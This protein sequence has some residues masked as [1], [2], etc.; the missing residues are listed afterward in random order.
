MLKH[1]ILLRS[2][3]MGGLAVLIGM[4]TWRVDA[5][6]NPLELDTPVSAV[7]ETGTVS[8]WQFEAYRDDVI[9]LSVNRAEGDLIPILSLLDS[10]EQ[11]QAQ[12]Q[13]DA[14]GNA[15]L[16]YRI[17]RFGQYIV[18]I[19]PHLAT[20]GSFNL[21]LALAESGRR[22]FEQGNIEYGQPAVQN[23]DDEIPYH[24]WTFEGENGQ[25]VDI[26]VTVL[27]GDLQP[28]IALTSPG[29]IILGRVEA[30]IDENRGRL[31]AVRLPGD[32]AYEVLVRRAGANFGFDGNSAGRYRLEVTLRNGANA[33]A[34]IL[35]P[36]ETVPGR[37]TIDSP[38]TR[39]S[40]EA[41]GK[42]LIEV[43]LAAPNCLVDLHMF[44][45]G[46]IPQVSAIGKSPFVYPVDFVGLEPDIIEVAAANCPGL[47]DIDFLIRISPYEAN[48][49]LQTLPENKEVFGATEFERWLFKGKAGDIINLSARHIDLRQPLEVR[50]VAPDQSQLYRSTN[51]PAFE[52]TLILQTDGFY[53]I[54]VTPSSPYFLQK[55]LIGQENHLFST[56]NPI[57]EQFLDVVETKTWRII[58][59]TNLE[60]VLVVEAP[61]GEIVAISRSTP[62]TP[63]RLDALV[64]AHPGRYRIKVYSNQRPSRLEVS[65]VFDFENLLLSEGKAILSTP[66][67]FH[68][69]QV[70]LTVGDIFKLRLENLR[71]DIPLPSVMLLDQTGTALQPQYQL[72]HENSLELIG[73]QPPKTGIYTILVS[74]NGAGNQ[75]TYQLETDVE[76]G[77]QETSGIVSVTTPVSQGFLPTS[78]VVPTEDYL[79][80]AFTPDDAALFEDAESVSLPNLI[81]GEIL[82]NERRDIWRLNIVR[83]QM[84][85][86][87]ATS[88]ENKPAPGITLINAEGVTVVEHWEHENPVS[89]VFY[90]TPI[91]STYYLVVTDDTQGGKYLLD[92]HIVPGLDETVS[93]V[94][95]A[96]PLAVGQPIIGELTSQTE[97]D[98][99]AFWGRQGDILSISADATM[100]GFVP[101]LTLTG[102]R[103]NEIAEA[104]FDAEQN[105]AQLQTLPLPESG[106]YTITVS[107]IEFEEGA[108]YGRYTLFVSPLQGQLEDGG[109]LDGT[110]YGTISDSF[111]EDVWL[112]GATAGETVSL[113]LEPLAVG[114]PTGLTIALADTS[115]EIFY[116]SQALLAEAKVV[117]QDIMLPRT[118]LYQVRV[119]GETPGRYMLNLVKNS[120][121]LLPGDH[122]I[123]Y[124]DTAS[125]IF[126]PGN[127]VDRW[128]LAGNQ[129]DVIAVALRPVRGDVS[130]V[131][132]EVEGPDGTIIGVGIDSGLGG[133]ARTE[134]IILPA[135]GIYSIL[136]GM[137]D[138]Q[139]SGALAYDLSVE[140]QNRLARSSGRLLPYNTTTTGIIYADDTQDVWLFEG[141][142]GDVIQVNVAGDGIL[143]PTFFLTAFN[144]AQ[145]NGQY[146][147]L[148]SRTG[149]ANEPARLVDYVLPETGAYAISVSGIGGTTGAYT[150][151]VTA[152]QQ[153]IT[154]PLPSGQSQAGNVK[155]GDYEVW[156][157]QATQGDK[158]S[159]TVEPI[160]RS[161]LAPKLSLLDSSG[162]ILVQELGISAEVTTVEN[163][164]LPDSGTYFL[165]VQPVA[166]DTQ[167]HY[168][169][170]ASLEENGGTLPNP[171]AYDDDAISALSDENV[172]QTWFF[173][174]QAGDVIALQ[175]FGTS[176]NLDTTL[177]LY[178]S[179]GNVIAAGDDTEISTDAEIIL[180]LPE[181]ERYTVEVARYGKERG[182][183]SGNYRL[184]L[185]LLYRPGTVAANPEAYLTYGERVTGETQPDLETADIWYFVGQA[186]DVINIDLQ[187]PTGNIPLLLSLSDSADNLLQEGVRIRERTSIENFTLPADG[188]YQ[189]AIQPTRRITTGEYIP[190]TLSLDL[191]PGEQATNSDGGFIQIGTSVSG[192]F[193]GSEKVHFWLYNGQAGEQISLSLL[194]LSGL[195]SPALTIFAPDGRVLAN[196]DSLSEQNAVTLPLNLPTSGVYQIA[197][198]GTDAFQNYRLALNS[199][200]TA[201]IAGQ[202]LLGRVEFG[203]LSDLEPQQVWLFNGEAGE[204]VAIQAIGEIIFSIRLENAEGAVLATS[205][206]DPSTKQIILPPI[207]LPAN[208]TYRVIVNREGGS[209]GD[210]QGR[211]RIRIS[212][213]ITLPEALT[214][215]PLQSS[216][217]T[218]GAVENTQNAYYIFYADP[219]V[220]VSLD[221]TPVSG[222][223]NP[224]IRILN[225]SGEVISISGGTVENLLV[226]KAGYYL[227][228]VANP[229]PLTYTLTYADRPSGAPVKRLERDVTTV[230]DLTSS[231]PVDY[232]SFEAT[233]GESLSIELSAFATTMR[234]DLV[235]FAPD[236][237]PMRT[238]VDGSDEVV[239][240]PIF[241]PRSGLYTLRVGTWL[242]LLEADE[243]GYSVRVR[244]ADEN[245]GLGSEGGTISETPVFGGISEADPS[246][247]W[248]FEGQAGNTI[249]ITLQTTSGDAELNVELIAPD[250]TPIELAITENG[251]SVAT[252]TM[253][254]PTNG[255]YTLKVVL[256]KQNSADTTAYELTLHQNQPSIQA[257]LAQAQ[258]IA[259]G[260]QVMGEI[261]VADELD[262]WV[263]FATQGQIITI[264]TQPE[265]SITL[266]SPNGTPLYASENGSLEQILL[267]EDGLY[268]VV[269]GGAQTS[270]TL[271][272]E[273]D[274]VR[275]NW[276]WTLA[277]GHLE[278]AVLTYNSPVHE[279]TLTGYHVGE[280]AIVV[281]PSSQAWQ[282]QT[283]VLNEQNEVIATGESQADGSVLMRLY[284]DES[285]G[286]KYSLIVTADIPGGDYQVLFDA[287]INA[288]TPEPV[289]EASPVT[290]RIS[291]FNTADEWLWEGN[292]SEPL[293]IEAVQL[294]G[295]FNMSIR[296]FAPGNLFLQEFFADENGFI[297]AENILLPVQGTYIIQVVRTDNILS[298]AQGLY[299]L[300]VEANPVP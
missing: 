125:G 195:A 46:V 152:L 16:T 297:R 105:T 71:T 198:V 193:A 112:V 292:P 135:T 15:T 158:L 70:P 259:I 154:L 47:D 262:A 52:Q 221:F 139:F 156:T 144:A 175:A 118:G 142:E 279:W 69:W 37:L 290:G 199:G 176:G 80:P 116:S 188:I 178:D 248:V 231:S 174:G 289:T 8:R 151:N 99:Y 238:Y 181:T 165:I 217:L 233:A 161:Q 150:L 22:A 6:E 128:L 68:Y 186:S 225:E 127:I 270:Y 86:F 218:T 64:L 45:D 129:G 141:H 275:T 247:R 192:D 92:I 184:D 169:I 66:S 239:F 162:N 42:H 216:I 90:R 41:F 44:S 60:A 146:E 115:G 196:L 54:E 204:T 210:A 58:A 253:L 32:G 84:V 109:V 113:A 164:I 202:L 281:R 9:T 157:I 36:N 207:L 159:L 131:G 201:A 261:S 229:M 257:I 24:V 140:R 223:S 160:R 39:Y 95:E 102:F 191:L 228:E 237:K 23:L 209:L 17:P 11:L 55:T 286:Q 208:D 126:T 249:S 100:R 171:L 3:L 56:Q 123:A 51:Q 53:T 1:K 242:N 34:N 271:L 266:I 124:G 180:T 285:N 295:D 88:L 77:F 299:Q 167:G 43:E 268:S 79:A 75:L 28:V 30:Q 172:L 215:Q 89:Q 19:S 74:N 61:T 108:E 57:L 101:Q 137:P 121:Y 224:Q 148:L 260:E 277:L 155:T 213:E 5:Q 241:I 7:L 25:A 173:D 263:F 133:G 222:E 110:A 163:Y 35:T 78:S 227:I 20:T 244:I 230:G 63:P 170:T 265:I 93:N 147:S 67:D 203:L 197:V 14:N 83:G 143:E 18:E 145:Q 235:L 2:L 234:P 212:A 97:T 179:A 130:S 293:T 134:N 98:T 104:T 40:I 280:Y 12:L 62:L 166:S 33:T 10:D 200:Q 206:I 298:D 168:E 136:V 65:A 117:V 26:T 276:R 73:F 182:Y 177:T 250:E 254:L 255:T 111:Q 50:V 283:F 282:A 38:L 296:V 107:A 4:L 264:T 87:S 273:P 153:S 187:F 205:Q 246:D 122:A 48:T 91:A 219:L 211:Y 103:G 119:S 300:R 94:V 256:E 269:L 288:I 82:P 287:G 185:N 240:E 190:Y 21:T 232:W 85:S 149:T 236:G 72:L 114:A 31:L 278:Q 274:T 245:N 284:L 132:F 226:Q 214:A 27:E 243:S 267:L 294:E 106:L 220:P 29:G 291:A 49:P 194:R 59:E 189:L 76:N 252:E 258:G 120:S 251:N 13:A 96:V 272:I 183:T 138:S 81:R